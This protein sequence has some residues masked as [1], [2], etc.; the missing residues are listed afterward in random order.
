MDELQLDFFVN[1]SLSDGP[2]VESIGQAMKAAKVYSN[3]YTSMNKLNWTKD[4][5][6]EFGMGTYIGHGLLQREMIEFDNVDKGFQISNVK[7]DD[8]ISYQSYYQSDIDEGIIGQ[9]TAIEKSLDRTDDVFQ[10]FDS[11]KHLLLDIRNYAD[12][13]ATE[14]LHFGDITKQGLDLDE[15]PD[16][17]HVRILVRHLWK[18]GVP[19]YYKDKRL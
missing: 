14:D 15:N 19:V 10:F 13:I 18:A 6:I 3:I 4:V 1:L 16:K 8:L 5:G 2:M 17:P 9:Q 11:D 7:F 12:Y